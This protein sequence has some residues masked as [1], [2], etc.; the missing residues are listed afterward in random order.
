M[1]DLFLQAGG[2]MVAVFSFIFAVL[3]ISG[4]WILFE[5]KHAVSDCD[6]CGKEEQGEY[7]ITLTNSRGKVIDTVYVCNDCGQLVWARVGCSQYG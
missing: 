4:C 1:A 5:L 7:K 3:L 6:F 2:I